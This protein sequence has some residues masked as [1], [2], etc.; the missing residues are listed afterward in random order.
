[1]S[2]ASAEADQKRREVQE[3][4]QKEQRRE[5]E[6]QDLYNNLNQKQ[7]IVKDQEKRAQRAISDKDQELNDFLKKCHDLEQQTREFSQK[8]EFLEKYNEDKEQEISRQK[9]SL[10]L[11]RTIIEDL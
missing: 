1:M 7:K 11:K 5:A 3:V 8:I 2:E 4:K 10:E 9:G 6:M